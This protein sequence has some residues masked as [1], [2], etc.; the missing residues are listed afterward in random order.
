M[1]NLNKPRVIIH[2][3]TL[4]GIEKI[5]GVLDFDQRGIVA[6]RPGDIVVTKHKPDSE[7]L[8]YLTQLGWDFS[9]VSFISP[10]NLENYTY[11]SIFYDKT[12]QGKIK[13]LGAYYID[14]YQNTHEEEAFGKRIGLSVY[15]NASLGL[16]FGTK[17]GFRKL[18][19][20]LKLP[21]PKGF[22]SIKTIHEALFLINKLFSTG[23]NKIIVK[24]DEGLSGAGQ[25]MIRKNEFQSLSEEE[26]KEILIKALSKV[27]QFSKT[28]GVTIE[29][30]V[31]GVVASPSIQLEVTPQSEIRILSMKDQI[32][33][34]EEQWYIGCS[35]PVSS[36][37]QKQQELF[38]RDAKIFTQE[39]VDRGFQ[40]YLGMDSILLKDGTVLWVE[41]N[42]RKP[43]TFYP[44]V[45]AEKVNGGTLKNLFYYACDFTIPK[46]RG[47]SCKVVLNSLKHYLYPMRDEKRGVIVYNTGALLDAGRFDVVC[48][49]KSTQDARFIF[50]QIKSLIDLL[51]QDKGGSMT[52]PKKYVPHYVRDLA[53][54]PQ[55]LQKIEWANSQ[56]PVLQLIR[57]RFSKE[58]PL[59][60]L[61]IDISCH[62][63]AETANL[64]RTLIAGGA[65]VLA[66]SGNPVS[67]QDDV[68]ASLVVDFEVMTF[69]AR[70][71]DR[72]INKKNVEYAIDRKPDIA[73][74]DGAE[75]ISVIYKRYPKL[76][77]QMIGGTEETTTGLHRF[78]S[79][80]KAGLLKFP[81][82]GVNDAQ[83]KHFFDNRY[84]T[85]QSTIDGILRATNMLLA[86]KTFVVVGYGWCGKGVAL[87]AKGMG[88]DV[89]VCDVDPVKALEAAMDGYRVMPIKEACSIADFLITVTGGMHVIDAKDLK[90]MKDGIVMG[91]SGHFNVEINLVALNK[92][93][94][95]VT[96]IRPSL[97]E[98]F[99]K[100]GRKIFLVGEGRLANLA[101]AEGHPAAVMDMSF[102]NQALATEYLVKN[103]KKLENKVYDIPREIDQWIAT[104]K[105]KTMGIKID[106]ITKEQD[107]YLNQW[108]K[109]GYGLI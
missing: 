6:A 91:N 50:D 98:Y 55:G 96:R 22:E 49:G 23:V 73:I 18:A 65:E 58:K 103:R 57:K 72:E 99:L 80:E 44:R 67:T 48:I 28:S 2:N 93:T 95:K 1:I 38:V 76:A 61:K 74:D 109:G 81:I 108:E 78:R 70:N 101:A 60:G 3:L 14:A 100:D 71:I 77:Q 10:E 17:S 20:Q 52:I 104:L 39:L 8:Y 43:G 9:R 46:F 13:S 75:F 42:I 34:G 86:G 89:V 66:H 35:Y 54:A 107:A 62:L 7:F 88:C 53:L 68:S 45:I 47:K 51:R 97:D 33:E 94:K 25:T 79:L 90:V 84:G 27:P 102:A 21:I 16:K 63:T 41:A 36:L 56:M 40:G 5:P 106:A 82:M 19:K 105:L 31:G 69:G 15:A 11:K 92:E 85:G 37:S 30:W 64:I 24:I 83:T 4:K 32:L 29:E 87:R 26:Q 12:V 59:K